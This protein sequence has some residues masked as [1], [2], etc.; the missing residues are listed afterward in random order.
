MSL[1]SPRN[2]VDKM[3]PDVVSEKVKLSIGLQPRPNEERV[4]IHGK[5]AR[6]SLLH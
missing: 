3:Q 6:S 5:P 4:S 2:E 1:I